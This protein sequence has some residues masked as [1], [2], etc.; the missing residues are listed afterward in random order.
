[1]MMNCNTQVA[2]L[3]HAEHM[4]TLRD[5][6]DLDAFLDDHPAR[7][8][9]DAAD[10]AF[11]GILTNVVAKL[12]AELTRHFTFEETHLFPVMVAAGEP[13]IAAF[14]TEEHDSIRPVARHLIG[15]ASPW[16][17]GVPLSAAGW[18]DFHASGRELC[19]REMLHIQKEE[20]GLL[21]AIAM[22]VDAEADARL[23]ALY[24]ALVAAECGAG[25][26]S[27]SAA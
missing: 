16:L 3:L 19:E 8:L 23:A 4:R 20:M 9:P 24:A 17:R 18:A 5:L 27:A 2:S 15:L 25:S 21:A 1:M 26:A 6:Q 10:P 22:F 7:R 11:Q 13:G 12:T 14:L